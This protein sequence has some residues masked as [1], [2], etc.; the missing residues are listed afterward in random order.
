[1][2]ILRN[3]TEMKCVRGHCQKLD[4]MIIGIIIV[5][6]GRCCSSSSSSNCSNISNNSNEV[7]IV[8]DELVM[9]PLSQ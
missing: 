6:N 3:E 1:M 9:L 4:R 7:V 5:L 8:V 2:S